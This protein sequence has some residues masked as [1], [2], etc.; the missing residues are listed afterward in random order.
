MTQSNDLNGAFLN[1]IQEKTDEIHS[2]RADK[3]KIKD[4]FEVKME[5]QKV[6]PLTLILIISFFV[7]I[8]AYRL[9]NFL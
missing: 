5:S 7:G 1:R 4:F 2:T 9:S 8:L 6:S 3:S